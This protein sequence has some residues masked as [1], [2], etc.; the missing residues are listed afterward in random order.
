MMNRGN[1][2]ISPPMPRIPVNAEPKTAEDLLE[3]VDLDP[4][5]QQYFYKNYEVNKLIEN[6]E[7][8]LQYRKQIE[9]GINSGF[10]IFYKGSE[11]SKMAQ[12]YMA[13]EMAAR[14]QHL[15]ELTKRLIP[16]WPPGCRYVVP[17][18][19]SQ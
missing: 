9:F 15:P 6:P 4:L 14:L 17:L 1:T 8:H 7:F 10:A 3:E 13:N 19:I 5:V 2:W 11:A 12:V 16:K 18:A